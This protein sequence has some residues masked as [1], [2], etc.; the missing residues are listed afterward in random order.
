MY[1]WTNKLVSKNGAYSLVLE[2]GGLVMCINNVTTK[3][4]KYGMLS[5]SGKHKP[6]TVI[7]ECEEENEGTYAYELRLGFST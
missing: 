7:L 1:Q 4:L 3:P 6:I 5:E 2:A